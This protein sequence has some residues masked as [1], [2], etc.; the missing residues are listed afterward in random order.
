LREYALN[1]PLLSSASKRFVG[2]IFPNACQVGD[3]C[4]Q[5]RSMPP[6]ATMPLHGT[7]IAFTQLSVNSAPPS[8]NGIKALRHATPVKHYPDDPLRI[9]TSWPT[10]RVLRHTCITALHDDGCIREQIR[11]ITG[12]TIASINEVLDR[13]TKLTA[14]QAGAALAKRPAHEGGDSA[15]KR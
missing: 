15:I 2:F 3:K 6:S 9:P 13:Y 8:P 11:A 14:D 1:D 7:P 10:M 12:H 4:L 5:R